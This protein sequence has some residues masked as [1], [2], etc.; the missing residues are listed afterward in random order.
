M[1]VVESP[2]IKLNSF[3]AS[4]LGSSLVK[5]MT[6][7]LAAIVAGELY[8]PGDFRYTNVESAIALDFALLRTQLGSYP[9]VTE[10]PDALL[11]SILRETLLSGI[12]EHGLEI[13][14]APN[15]AL[16]GELANRYF[17]DN[18]WM[19]RLR[20]DLI[21]VITGQYSSAR[22][23]LSPSDLQSGLVLILAY[24]LRTLQWSISNLF[25]GNHDLTELVEERAQM[26]A[27]FQY[28]YGCV[29]L[30][31]VGLTEVEPV[32]LKIK[33]H[34]LLV[35]RMLDLV[36]TPI[37]CILI[38]PLLLALMLILLFEDGPIFYSQHR[39]GRNGRIFSCLK[40]RTMVPNAEVLLAELIASDPAAHLEWE[41][42]VKLRNDPRTTKLG[43]FLRRTS[44]DELPQLLNVLK[45]DMSLVGPRPM[46]LHERERWGG[47]YRPYTSI[48]PGVTGPWQVYHR[49]ESDYESRFHSLEYYLSN[50]SVLRDMKY[51][52]L[53]LRVPFSGR[54]AY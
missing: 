51:L 38:S 43:R 25:G 49:N 24:D 48:Q 19:E 8:A 52:I 20:P 26:N 50:W 36:L 34:M 3:A 40:F 7:R 32:Q 13:S 21:H 14:A 44:L 47:F 28:R 42:H 45:G 41:T 54:G 9:S 23:I 53:T 6:F 4:H 35:K 2:Q 29:C 31:D 18:R 17:F 33:P 46:A 39:I 1:S 5:L 11:K 12:T 27:L 30:V 10:D 16:A 37:L 22:P 15:L